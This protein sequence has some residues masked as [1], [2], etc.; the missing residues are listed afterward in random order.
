M[1]LFA[2]LFLFMISNMIFAND[3]YVFNSHKQEAQFNH[4]IKELRCLVCQNQDIANSN[5]DFAN[6]VKDSVYTMVSLG[7]TDNEIVSAMTMRFGDYI[8]FK[9]PFKPVTYVLWFGPLLFCI[10][11]LMVFLRII[12]GKE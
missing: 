9:P 2:V 5:S 1:K 4:L 12:K 8:L 7:K 10:I 6:D 3:I 11:G